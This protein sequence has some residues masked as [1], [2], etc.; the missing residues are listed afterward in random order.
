MSKKGRGLVRLALPSKG[1]LAESAEQLLHDAGI[2]FTP[3]GRTLHVHC[4]DLDLELL[5]ARADDI[6]RWTADGAVELGITGRNQIVETG[7]E[8]DELLALGF[9]GCRLAVAVPEASEI[10]DVLDLA[11][12]RLATSYP[13]TTAAALGALGIAAE[14]VELTGSVELAP[15]LGA[16][17]AVVDLVSSGETLRQNGLREIASLLESEAVLVARPGLAGDQAAL[18][19]E[20]RLVLESVL[21]ARPKRYLMLNA[22]DDRLDD[23]LALLPGLDAPTVLPLARSGM[24]AVHAVIDADDVVRL[25]GPLRSAGASS[26]LVLPIEHL[27]P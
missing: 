12:R 23:V 25:L 5:F 6:P 17:D 10:R 22:R 18:V 3:N 4:L 24:H 11:G 9:G 13:R 16:A 26:L 19:E 2:G 14:L 1:R 21:A 8:L 27:I 15:R 20:I 7:V